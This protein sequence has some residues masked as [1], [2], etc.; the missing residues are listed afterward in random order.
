MSG[1]SEGGIDGWIRTACTRVRALGRVRLAGGSVLPRR[2]DCPEEGRGP[3][4][5]RQ[6]RLG[7][8]PESAPRPQKI[9]AAAP[10]ANR[11]QK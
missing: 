6:R 9:F 10:L 7:A 3:G 8:F 5:I 2:W 1:V 4:K 11:P